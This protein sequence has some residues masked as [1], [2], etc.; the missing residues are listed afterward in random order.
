MASTNFSTHKRARVFDRVAG[1]VVFRNLARALVL[2]GF[3]TV[4]ANL[5]ACGGGGGDDSSE[6]PPNFPARDETNAALLLQSDQVLAIMQSAARAQS[7]PVA[8]AVVDRRGVI[9]GV[10]TNFGR[11]EAFYQDQCVTDCPLA[12]IALDS[13]S[14]CAVI[15]RSVQLA[16]TAAF[17]SANETP[18]TSRSVRFLSGE[19]FPPD[20]RNTGAAALFGIENTNRGCSFDTLPSLGPSRPD[21]TDGTEVQRRRSDADVIPRAAS[22]ATLFDANLSCKSS[23]LEA[24]KCG[25]TTGIATLP[26]AVPIYREGVM[27]GGVGVAVRGIAADP[28]PVAAFDAPDE[29]LRRDDRDDAFTAAEFAARAFA[30]D[31]TGIPTVKAKGLTDLCTPT[32][33][34]DMPGCCAASSCRFGFL[35]PLPRS[36]EPVIFVD[37]IEIPE[38][39][40]DPHVSGVGS[41][42]PL[43]EPFIVAPQH[44]TDVAASS[45]LVTPRSASAGGGPLSSDDVESII[46]AGIAEAQRV[47]AAIRLPLQQRTA[48]V[49][50]ISDLNGELLGVFRMPDAT[51][52]SIDVAVAKA[53]NVTY[54][55]SEAILPLDR[56]DCPDPSVAGCDDEFFFPAGTAIT[57]RTISF[58]S[59]P[60]FPPGIDGSDPG[61]FR[62]IFVNDSANACT[63]AGE[64]ANG[65]QN[66][67]VFFPGSAPLY[68]DG[69]LAG[70]FGVSGDG[71]EQ[72]DLVTAA[73]TQAAPGFE[74]PEEIRADQIQVRGD[75]RLPYLKFNRNPG[76]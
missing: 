36:I 4:G 63:N 10:A 34:V 15:N 1:A 44:S 51:V 21:L 2:A 12:D 17:F 39:E 67:I 28:D 3:A 16:R 62:R 52:F 26:G 42:A 73:G 14:D 60:F 50:A 49:L 30:G 65:R 71:V 9:L 35:P 5:V 59:Q 76:D 61:P 46:N 20:I 69:V 25:C 8:V 75:I 22:L 32:P 11:D 54:F 41:G 7:L 55:S 37:G 48:M 68:V 33:G 47:R 31:E 29:V 24:D 58:A 66:G 64:P 72:D 57:N 56:R 19:H 38:V 40:H 45:W 23:V 13:A 27:V 6:G 74:A 53:R 18:L 70:G 43:T